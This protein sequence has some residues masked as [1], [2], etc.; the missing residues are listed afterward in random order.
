MKAVVDTN[1]LIS[2]SLWQGPPAR[3]LEAAA[4]GK[5]EL[6]MSPQL[7]AEFSEVVARPKFAARVA[8]AASTPEAL[9]RK[10]ADEV[11]IV[12]TVALPCPPNLRSEG[13]AR[14]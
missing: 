7:L 9:A 13:L 6:V 10:L 4:I 11:V 14:A 1:I 8:A 12:S 2:G 3:L 5:V